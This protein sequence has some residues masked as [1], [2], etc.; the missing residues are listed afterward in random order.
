MRIVHVAVDNWRNFKSLE[1]ALGDRLF[2]V[3]PNA[4]GKSNLLDIFRFLADVAG[5]GGLATAVERR[6][7]ISKVR[8]LFARNNA[9]GRLV[10]DVR[11]R[12]GETDWRY[13]LAIRGEKGGLNRPI[14][15]EELVEKDGKT[16]LR[17]PD[18]SDSRDAERL[19][20]TH[21]E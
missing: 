15:D 14:V 4:S 9:G 6:D 16:L 12:D 13:R 19:T 2:V 11:L 1:F 18:R 17:R 5:P 3:G 20:Q 10:I 7:G 8:S 21:L